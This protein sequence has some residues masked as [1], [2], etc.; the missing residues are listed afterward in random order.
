MGAEGRETSADDGRGGGDS[1]GGGG[2]TRDMGGGGSR[3]WA[4]VS[5]RPAKDGRATGAAVVA[6][7]NLKPRRKHVAAEGKRAKRWRD[8]QEKSL[9]TSGS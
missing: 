9:Y 4:M 3:R 7:F 2:E 5:Y 1:K 8:Q 6:I